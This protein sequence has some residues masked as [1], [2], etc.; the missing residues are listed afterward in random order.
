MKKTLA[1]IFVSVII[2][3]VIV[4]ADEGFDRMVEID[5]EVNALI[6]ERDGIVASKMDTTTPIGEYETKYMDGQYRVGEDIPAGEYVFFCTGKYGGSLKETTDSNGSD[7]VDSEYFDY[8]VIYTLT[9]GNY[10]E[11]EGAMAV[12]SSD[13]TELV[14]NKGSGTFKVGTHIPAGEYKIINTTTSGGS[15]KI[16]NSSFPWNRDDRV[17]TGYFSTATYLTI[18]DGEYLTIDDA[19]FME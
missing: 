1:V 11:I 17:D 9:E 18:H 6:S 12:P 5:S 2:G 8:C 3:S 19:L 10:V 7:R 14:L 15:Y 16:W 13:V 4:T